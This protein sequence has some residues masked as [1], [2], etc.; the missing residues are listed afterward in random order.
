M[1]KR[2]CIR[3][4]FSHSWW[5]Q[6]PEQPV[7]SIFFNYLS[8]INLIIL[9]PG[10]FYFSRTEPAVFK[11]GFKSFWGWKRFS[12]WSIDKNHLR[13]SFSELQFPHI[14]FP[15]IN[16]PEG[17]HANHF[18]YHYHVSS[19]LHKKGMFLTQYGS[20]HGVLSWNGESQVTVKMPSKQR[21]S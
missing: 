2:S 5:V 11:L 15:K 17:T 8:L 16:F 20:Y 4:S 14:F 9:F 19:T 1:N 3:T 12:T 21:H 6:V 10:E 13:K 18:H 7:S